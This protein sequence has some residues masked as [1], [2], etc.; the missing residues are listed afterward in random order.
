L[1][2]T[3]DWP[4]LVRASWGDGSTAK[5]RVR[6][7]EYPL[8]TAVSRHIGALPFL[9]VAVDDEPN[10]RSD[11]GVIEAG[12]ISLLSNFGWAVVDPPSG[13]WLGHLADREA[14]RL[15]GL[16]NVDHVRNPHRTEF[17]ETL[18]RHIENLTAV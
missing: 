14:V 10:N 6:E 1:L 7:D 11:R 3:G 8:E 13:S 9:W 5:G 16:W 17:L 15:S 4:D 12:A 2:A 18:S